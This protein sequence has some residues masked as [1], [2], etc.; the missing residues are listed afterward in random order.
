MFEKM[1][2]F[3][4]IWSL[5]VLNY[6]NAKPMNQL[7]T[8]MKKFENSKYDNYLF[9]IIIDISRKIVLICFLEMIIHKII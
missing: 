8:D 6:A 2:N 1:M 3:L 9:M 4:L 7:G 5:I